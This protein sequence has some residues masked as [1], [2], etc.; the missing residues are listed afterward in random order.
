MNKALKIITCL[1][2]VLF[3]LVGLRWLVDPAGAA[4]EL[5]MPL[6]DGIGRSAQIGDFGSFFITL[7]VLILLGVFTGRREWL[8]APALMLGLA[9]AIRALAW[10]VYDAAFATSAIVVE[11]VVTAILLFAASRI[12]PAT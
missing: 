10:G 9:A 5:G 4:G 11:V 12:K 6:L 8:Y 2:A 3:A 7:S 1:P